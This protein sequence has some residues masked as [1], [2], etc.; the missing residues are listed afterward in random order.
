[1]ERAREEAAKREAEK[2]EEYEY[3]INPAPAQ[4]KKPRGPPTRKTASNNLNS[5]T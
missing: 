4:P 2:N 3:A 5:L 1:M